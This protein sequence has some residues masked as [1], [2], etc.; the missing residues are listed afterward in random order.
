MAFLSFGAWRSR[1][2]VPQNEAST[3]FL[4]VLR[5]GGVEGGLILLLGLGSEVAQRGFDFRGHRARDVIWTIHPTVSFSSQI[6]PG[7]PML[8]R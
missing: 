2:A 5:E 8:F 4:H 7:N 1:E 3:C 6:L